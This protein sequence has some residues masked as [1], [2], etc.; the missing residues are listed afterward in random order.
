MCWVALSTNFSFSSRDQEDE[1]QSV[2]RASSTST[3]RRQNCRI[4]I[5][6]SVWPDLIIK[7]A[8]FLL[9]LLRFKTLNVSK[10]AW[11]LYRIQNNTEVTWF[12]TFHHYSPRNY[13]FI[14]TERKVISS[15][16]TLILTHSKPKLV[17]C[18]VHNQ[19]FFI[20]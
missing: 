19:V 3:P 11:N 14:K 1:M 12:S 17:N 20:S 8:Q 2:I 15:F 18:T 10:T 6:S 4:V 9:G 13:Y 5:I 16:I 7:I